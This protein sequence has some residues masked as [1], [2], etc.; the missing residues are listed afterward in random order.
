MIKKCLSLG[1]SVFCFSLPAASESP[2]YVGISYLDLEMDDGINTEHD[3]VLFRFGG[4]VD[5]VV[6]LEVRAGTGVSGESFTIGNQEFDYK[7]DN[8]LAFY[9]KM[10]PFQHS[11]IRPYGMIGVIAGEL[12]LGS[13]FESTRESDSSFA[14]GVDILFDKKLTA[15]FEYGNYY[16]EN[17]VEISGFMFGISANY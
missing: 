12:Q 2:K 16:S 13:G 3:V 14:A 11:M 1:L 9:G 8:I 7:L 5:E 10:S 17:D 6:S 4:Q 15:N